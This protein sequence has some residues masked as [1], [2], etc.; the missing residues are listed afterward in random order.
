[1]R[2]VAGFAFDELDGSSV[3]AHARRLEGMNVREVAEKV[4]RGDL[5]TAKGKGSIGQVLQTWFAVPFSDNRPHADLPDARVLGSEV[6]GIEIKI[7]PMRQSSKRD[8]LRAKERNVIS[9]INYSSLPTE[10]WSTASVR[11]KLEH[12]LF[13]FYLYDFED[14]RKSTVLRSVLWSLRDEPLSKRIEKDWSRTRDLV[15]AGHASLLTESD[16]ETVILRTCRKGAGGP[17]EQ[18]ISIPGSKE[19]AWKRA[20]S[21]APGHLDVVLA[22]NQPAAP[23]VSFLPD[24]TA[25]TVSFEDAVLSQLKALVGMRIRELDPSRDWSK[26][27]KNAAALVVKRAL[28]LELDPDQ[29][30]EFVERR[31]VVRVLPVLV[32]SQKLKEAVSFPVMRLREFVDEEWEESTLLSYLQLILFI[33]TY[34]GDGTV[35]QGNRR[36]GK[37]WFWTP[38]ERELDDIHSEWLHYQKLVRSGACMTKKDLRGRL[39]SGLLKESQTKYIHMRPHGRDADDFDEDRFGN[40]IVKQSF[41]LNK[42]FLEHLLPKEGKIRGGQR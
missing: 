1:L 18:K 28:R 36:I 8:L 34:L 26:S 7:V 15:A 12:I 40:R 30:V 14:W 27:H 23:L 11:H 4:G 24:T 37:S 2:T 25:S 32:K 31:V 19:P 35:R 10:R 41:W 6:V 9:M 21:L 42:R 5:A 29:I 17:K 33:P 38:T 16:K 22:R 39:V 20:F 3:V 13:I